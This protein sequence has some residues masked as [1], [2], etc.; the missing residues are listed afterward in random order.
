MVLS[1]AINKRRIAERRCGTGSMLV[2]VG[3]AKFLVI[4]E[5][6]VVVGRRRRHRADVL[7]VRRR[8]RCPGNHRCPQRA[9]PWSLVPRSRTIESARRSAVQTF[10]NNMHCECTNDSYNEPVA[11]I[12]VE[13][14]I[15]KHWELLTSKGCMGHTKTHSIYCTTSA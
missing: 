11:D 4:M 9:A 2:V 3:D 6:E 15:A 7:R 10:F 12:R 13:K 1:A 14:E 5:G 8:T